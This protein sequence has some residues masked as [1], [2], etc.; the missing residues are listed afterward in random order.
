MGFAFV[1]VGGDGEQGG[2]GIQDELTVW[3]SGFRWAR[4]MMR[5]PS[6]SGQACIPAAQAPVFGL[7]D[8]GSGGMAALYL[9]SFERIWVGAAPLA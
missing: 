7:C 9:D 5:G 1:A 3:L 4:A 2:G 8:T 6:V